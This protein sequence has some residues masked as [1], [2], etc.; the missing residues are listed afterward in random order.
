MITF[1]IPCLGFFSILHHH[2]KELIPFK[3]RLDYAE[4]Y[5]ISPNDTIELRGL[6]ETVYWSELD[7]WNYTDPSNPTAPEY[8]IYTGLSL[9]IYFFAYLLISM[10]HLFALLMTKIFT[11]RNFKN[12]QNKTRKFI[13]I[14]KLIFHLLS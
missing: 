8:T 2:K 3:S 4:K 9:K 7:R 10:L 1:F 5:G 13:H 12:F 11:A 14:L 6:Q